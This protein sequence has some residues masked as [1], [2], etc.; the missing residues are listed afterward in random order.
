[1]TSVRVCFNQ[2]KIN[3]YR[4]IS[5]KESAEDDCVVAIV[6]NKTDLCDDDEKRPVKYKDGAKLADVYFILFY[7]ISSNFIFIGIWMSIF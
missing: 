2:K 4:F 7:I 6:G 5:F 3:N 1:M